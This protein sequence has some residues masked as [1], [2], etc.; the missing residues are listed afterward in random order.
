MTCGRLLD[1]VQLEVDRQPRKL[2]STVPKHVDRTLLDILKLSHKS[3]YFISC[4]ETV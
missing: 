2:Y 1:L 3:C 4:L